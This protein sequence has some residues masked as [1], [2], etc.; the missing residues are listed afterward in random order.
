MSC[1]SCLSNSSKDRSDVDVLG[2][3]T[4]LQLLGDP[5]TAAR[6]LASPGNAKIFG[7]E[8]WSQLNTAAYH[9]MSCYNFTSKAQNRR[10]TLDVNEKES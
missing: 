6:A 4:L 8:T 5:R 10:E 1:V 3:D 7:R 2:R 9:C